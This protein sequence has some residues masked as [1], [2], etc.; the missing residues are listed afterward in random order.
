MY[1]ENLRAKIVS[2]KN[3]LIKE[4]EKSKNAQV[5]GSCFNGCK[6]CGIQKSYRCGK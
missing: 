5:T 4:R 3:Y 1:I 2:A 6:G